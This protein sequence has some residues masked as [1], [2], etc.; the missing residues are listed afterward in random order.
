MSIQRKKI[1]DYVNLDDLDTL[2]EK[3]IQQ[4]NCSNDAKETM[5]FCWD[6]LKNE[7]I[8]KVEYLYTKPI[9]KDRTEFLMTVLQTALNKKVDYLFQ[10]YMD[11]ALKPTFKANYIYDNQIVYCSK[12]T[13]YYFNEKCDK[14]YT[15]EIHFFLYHLQKI[16]FAKEVIK[17]L[18]E[19]KL[20]SAHH[21]NL[22]TKGNISSASA[23]SINSVK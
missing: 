23:D 8:T 17:K 14:S 18:A 3:V 15:K 1:V 16:V 7:S 6:F 2:L 4:S 9:N 20:T 19:I 5:L 13:D 22:P 11:N 12:L 10:V 21:A